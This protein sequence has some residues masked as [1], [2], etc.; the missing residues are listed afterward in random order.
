[1]VSLKRER[2]RGKRG[3]LRKLSYKEEL[4]AQGEKNAGKPSHGRGREMLEWKM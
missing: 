3:R 2:E 4:E 1:M